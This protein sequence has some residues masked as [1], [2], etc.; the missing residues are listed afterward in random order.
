MTQGGYEL[1]CIILEKRKICKNDLVIENIKINQTE[2]KLKK[3][4]QYINREMWRSITYSI[5]SLSSI[6]L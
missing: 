4:H 6:H 5:I 3:A 1:V 2:R